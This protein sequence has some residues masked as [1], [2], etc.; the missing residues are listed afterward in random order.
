[1]SEANPELPA[2]QPELDEFLRTA[3]DYMTPPNAMRALI[4]K[5]FDFVDRDL[6][7]DLG[8]IQN[9]LE[10]TDHQLQLTAMHPTA[11]SRFL[12]S[13]FGKIT[14][15]HPFTDEPKPYGLAVSFYPFSD[16]MGR[17]LEMQRSNTERNIARLREDTGVFD[18]PDTQ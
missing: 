1:M 12:V 4:V 13:G 7:D 9:H 14:A 16:P 2:W 11:A 3:H 6:A 15:K 18:L 10:A 17:Y 5:L 8:V